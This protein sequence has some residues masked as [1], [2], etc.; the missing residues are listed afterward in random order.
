M[1]RLIWS[2]DPLAVSRLQKSSGKSPLTIKQLAKLGIPARTIPR[3]QA[4]LARLNHEESFSAEVW[5][6]IALQIARHLV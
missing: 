1:A 2:I 3:V 6:Q 4:E 5:P